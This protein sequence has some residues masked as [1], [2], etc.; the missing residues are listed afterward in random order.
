MSPNEVA[1]LFNLVLS[2]GCCFAIL[3][4]TWPFKGLTPQWNFKR[5]RYT[6]TT[7]IMMTWFWVG[8]VGLFVNNL[9]ALLV[10]PSIKDLDQRVWEGTFMV[11]FVMHLLWGLHNLHQWVIIMR[12]A[13]KGTEG[14]WRRPYPMFVFSLLGA[15]GSGTLRNGIAL[16]YGV[17]STVNVVTGVYEL[18]CF[19]LDFADLGYFM[20]KEFSWGANMEEGYGKDEATTELA[21]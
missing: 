12:G 7:H 14:E 16:W 3:L 2:F 21:S 9:Y 8:C 5:L 10:Y 19:T 18:L 13:D 17:N 1:V 6:W 20:V 4:A 15:C 11:N